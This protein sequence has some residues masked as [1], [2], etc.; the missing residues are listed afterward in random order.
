MVVK[1]RVLLCQRDC[2]LESPKLD[3]AALEALV[4]D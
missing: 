3:L 4:A 1:K 2:L